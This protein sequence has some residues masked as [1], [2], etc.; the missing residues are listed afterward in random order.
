MRHINR[1][2]EDWPLLAALAAIVAIVCL[3]Q[4]DTAGANFERL[5]GFEALS[6]RVIL[7]TFGG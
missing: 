4:A 3:A 6:N 7:L 1:E 5:L 2:R